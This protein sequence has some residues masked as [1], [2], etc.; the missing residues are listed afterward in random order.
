MRG[1]FTRFGYEEVRETAEF[2]KT[3]LIMFEHLEVLGKSNRAEGLKVGRANPFS[4]KNTLY[5]GTFKQA[6][7]VGA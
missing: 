3:S 4:L 2:R 6:S 1:L 7:Q 5:A